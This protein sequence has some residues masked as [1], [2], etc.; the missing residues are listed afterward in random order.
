MMSEGNGYDVREGRL[1]C[2]R[3]KVIMSEGN[4]N[5]VKK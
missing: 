4:G 1:W 2:P 3:V 5:G